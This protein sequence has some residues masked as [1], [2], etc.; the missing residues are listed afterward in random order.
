MSGLMQFDLVSP[1]AALV[2]MEIISVER[3]LLQDVELALVKSLQLPIKTVHL[4]TTLRFFHREIF[5]NISNHSWGL[6]EL[7]ITPVILILD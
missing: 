3:E 4:R 6:W 1:E 5:L 7:Q 2:S